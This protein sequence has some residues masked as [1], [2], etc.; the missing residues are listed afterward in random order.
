MLEVEKG[1]ASIKIKGLTK[2]RSREVFFIDS[3]L[4]TNPWIDKDSKGG[5]ILKNLSEKKI[6]FAQIINELL[7]RTR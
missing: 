1:L 5:E 7:S 4:N 2:N 6:A 3:V